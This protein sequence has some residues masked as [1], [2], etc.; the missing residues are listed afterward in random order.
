MKQTT[1][2]LIL[3]NRANVKLIVYQCKN[4]C[5]TFVCEHSF[6]LITDLILFLLLS[7]IRVMGPRFRFVFPY[8]FVCVFYLCLHRVH[9]VWLYSFCFLFIF[10]HIHSFLFIPIF[11]CRGRRRKNNIMHEKRIGHSAMKIMCSW[12][13]YGTNSDARFEMHALYRNIYQ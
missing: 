10:D 11:M 2:V 13:Y 8:K 7:W 5:S 1:K 6:R 4:R 12:Q 9:F 3:R